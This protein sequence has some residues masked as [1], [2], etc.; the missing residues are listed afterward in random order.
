[1]LYILGVIVV[2]FVVGLLARFVLPGEDKMGLVLTALC[3]IG[4]AFVGNFLARYI[5][6]LPSTQVGEWSLGGL[7]T[8]VIGAVLVLIIVRMVRR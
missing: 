2:G 3:G 6:F 1:M 4:G 7:F 8:A 5:P